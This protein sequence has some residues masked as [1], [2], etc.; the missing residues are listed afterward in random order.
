[1]E[2]T[3]CELNSS[4]LTHGKRPLCSLSLKQVLLAAQP[5]YGNEFDLQDNEGERKTHFDM[6]GSAPRLVLKH[7]KSIRKTA[8]FE[9]LQTPRAPVHGP[10]RSH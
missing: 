8:N 5:L 2:G 10:L 4:A 1:M 9:T 7:G 3:P 6:K